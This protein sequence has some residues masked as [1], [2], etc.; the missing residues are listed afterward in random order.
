MPFLFLHNHH[1]PSSS[2]PPFMGVVNL[3][4][5]LWTAVGSVH[6]LNSEEQAKTHRDFT[7]LSSSAPDNK[8]LFFFKAQ[9]CRGVVDLYRALWTAVGS[10]HAWNSEKRAKTHRDF[11]SLSSSSPDNKILCFFKTQPCRGVVDLDHALWTVVGSV[12]AWNLE[13]TVKIHRDFTRLSSSP[14]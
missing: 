14:P 9:P 6:A 4:R 12:H 11:T 7:R 1:L 3:D 5:A 2:L 13:K 10:V 8:I